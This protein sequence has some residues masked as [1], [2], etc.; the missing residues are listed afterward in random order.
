MQIGVHLGADWNIGADWCTHWCRLVYTLV[1]LGVHIGAAW[2][3]HWCR[4]VYPL[5]QIGTL[6]HI[7]IAGAWEGPVGDKVDEMVQHS[8]VGAHLIY[9]A[10][11]Y[12]CIFVCCI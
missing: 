5:V 12:F 11:L 8:Q 6:V 1:Q 9:W 7:A 10:L 4:L 2:C 3:T